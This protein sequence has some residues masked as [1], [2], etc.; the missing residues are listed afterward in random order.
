MSTTET[1]NEAAAD[2]TLD[3]LRSELFATLRALRAGKIK[4]ADA[5]GVADLSQ[6]IINTA[7]VEVDFIKA[8]GPRNARPTGFAGQ[9]LEHQPGQPGR[10][11]VN[12]TATKPEPGKGLPAS[13]PRH[14]V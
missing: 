2:N 8:V 4:L 9:L 3:G 10:P 14:T 11:T 12:G 13:G 6:A 1:D 7:K 5:K